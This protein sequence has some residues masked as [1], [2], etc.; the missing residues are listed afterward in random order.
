[1]LIDGTALD[2]PAAP[3]NDLLRPG[4]DAGRDAVAVVSAQRSLSWAELDR[5]ASALAGATAV[6]ASSRATVSPR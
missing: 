4:L 5:G 6:S 1:M 2:A 3:L